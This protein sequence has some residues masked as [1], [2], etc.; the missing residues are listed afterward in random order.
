[1]LANLLCLCK[2]LTLGKINEL[3]APDANCRGV[4]LVSPLHR[5]TR[6]ILGGTATDK[7]RLA[8]QFD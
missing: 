7:I 8:E 5:F 1:M 3:L 2:C 4:E 6:E